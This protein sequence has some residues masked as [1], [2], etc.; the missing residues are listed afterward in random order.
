MDGCTAI[1][2]FESRGWVFVCVARCVVF[3][4]FCVSSLILGGGIGAFGEAI[5]ER[6]QSVLIGL[7]PTD[8]TG[9]GIDCF[10]EHCGYTVQAGR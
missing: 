7:T 8:S 3:A 4:T 1:N 10:H 2:V 6:L 5:E 9:R